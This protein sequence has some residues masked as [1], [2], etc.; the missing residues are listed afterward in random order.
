MDSVFS[1][2][3][4]GGA[5]LGVT[6]VVAADVGPSLVFDMTDPA[7]GSAVAGMPYAKVEALHAALGSWLLDQLLT[8]AVTERQRWGK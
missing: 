7:L 3:S 8:G 2:T 5:T 6:G 1:Y 4:T